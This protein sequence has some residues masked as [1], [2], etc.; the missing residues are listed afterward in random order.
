MHSKTQSRDTCLALK[1]RRRALSGRVGRVIRTIPGSC[2]YSQHLTR[3]RNRSTSDCFFLH[4]SSTY[5]YAPKTPPKTTHTHT[6]KKIPQKPDR[7]TTLQARKHE[8]AHKTYQV[9]VLAHIHFLV[10]KEKEIHKIC[11]ISTLI[12]KKKD[13]RKEKHPSQQ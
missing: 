5:L 8:S 3:R 9:L 13:E 10:K 4:S 12:N 6:Q 1:P 2:L 7:P 11:L